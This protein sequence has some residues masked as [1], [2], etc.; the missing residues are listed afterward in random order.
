[1]VNWFSTHMLRP[2]S[3]ERIVS[4]AT[5]AGT[6]GS[7]HAR[8]WSWIPISHRIQELIQ[9]GCRSYN[10]KTLRRKHRG[11]SSWSWIMQIFLNM[12]QK[13]Q[14]IKEKIDALGFIKNKSMCVLKD[15]IKKVNMQSREWEK[16]ICKSCIW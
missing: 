5:V 10:Y 4:S 7:P 15:T 1:M 3:R 14:A 12:T 16:Y 11:K 6:N 2:F 8:E 13:A 9:N